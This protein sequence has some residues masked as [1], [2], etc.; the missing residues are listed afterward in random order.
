MHRCLEFSDPCTINVT[1]LARNPA[2]IDTFDFIFV[3][4]RAKVGV[5]L[6][7]YGY[8]RDSDLYRSEP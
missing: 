2:D 7:F 1:K 8:R 4:K 3:T 6:A 5:F